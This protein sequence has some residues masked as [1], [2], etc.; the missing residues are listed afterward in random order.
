MKNQCDKDHSDNAITRWNR[1]DSVEIQNQTQIT[2][3]LNDT[4]VNK[5][6]L[7]AVLRESFDVYPAACVQCGTPG[8]WS[9]SGSSQIKDKSLKTLVAPDISPVNHPKKDGVKKMYFEP[10]IP[11]LK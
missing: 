9:N 3:P 5:E 6:V 7:P 4:Q 11:C 8:T 1:V 10:R 2:A